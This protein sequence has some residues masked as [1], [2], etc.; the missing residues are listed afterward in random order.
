MQHQIDLRSCIG[1][2]EAVSRRIRIVHNQKKTLSSS[3]S[4][5]SRHHAR[6]GRMPPAYRPGQ[7]KKI[8]KAVMQSCVFASAGLP[9]R[10]SDL[11]YSESAIL[12]EEGGQQLANTAQRC[13]ARLGYL[14]TLLSMVYIDGMH[15]ARTRF[16]FFVSQ[17]QAARCLI[18]LSATL[19]FESALPIPDPS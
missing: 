16:F 8:N 10:D 1:S 18:N 7:W 4:L 11:I 14:S 13:S 19:S 17:A 9:A 2:Q 15:I 5:V 6:Q 3:P 12:E